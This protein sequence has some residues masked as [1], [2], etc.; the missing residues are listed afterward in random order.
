[1][2]R[3]PSNSA[4][5]ET[6]PSSGNEDVEPDG[7]VVDASA[8]SGE[9]VVESS[10]D[11]VDRD[12][13]PDL[14][15]LSPTLLARLFGVPLLITGMIVGCAIVVVLSFGSITE[16]RQRPVGELLAILESHTGEKTV[17]VLLPN[18]KEVWQV[19]RELA[20]RLTKKEVELSAEDLRVTADR[21]AALT[22][23]MGGRSSSLSD[24]GRRQLHLVMAALA[25]TELPESVGPL[26]RLLD[27]PDA[28]T[29]QVALSQLGLLG[30]VIGPSSGAI[31]EIVSCLDDPEPVV[32][33]T[34]CV[35]LSVL[36]DGG[37]PGVVAGLESAYYDDDREVCWNAALALARMGNSI[38]KPL[39]LDML[40]RRYWEDEVLVRTASSSG[41]SLEYALPPAAVERYLLASIE[42]ASNL[43]DA[44]VRQQIG[45]L[46]GDSSPAIKDAVLRA[47]R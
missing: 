3:I 25:L 22:D 8:E 46:S 30:D 26:V 36:G 21:L 7:H 2:E 43:D 4:E 39:I 19:A 1:M 34:A 42:A 5:R 47:L 32:R 14:E 12:G 28:S 35:V 17:G 23:E 31:S 20:L 27:D 10:A 38:G 15:S 6:G 40:E 24:M 37:N 18:E 13:D 16:D 45:R 41:T 11:Q 33:T 44:E 29:R 9:S